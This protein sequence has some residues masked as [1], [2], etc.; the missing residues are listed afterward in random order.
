MSAPRASRWRTPD[1]PPHARDRRAASR[2]LPA[3]LIAAMAEGGTARAQNVIYVDTYFGAP[4]LHSMHP[5]GSGALVDSLPAGTLPEGLAFSRTLG[6]LALGNSAWA[7]GTL[8]TFALSLAPERLVLAGLSCARGVAVDDRTGHIFWTTSK[9]DS[10]AHIERVDPAGTNHVTVLDLGS[11]ANPRGIAI[12]PSGRMFYAD[13]DRGHVYAANLDGSSPLTFPTNLSLAGPWGV[14]L[15]TVQKHVYWCNYT[16]GSIMSANY[17]GSGAITVYAGLQNPTYLALDLSTAT[18]YW[19]EAGG[20]T[21]RVRSGPMAGSVPAAASYPIHGYGGIVF[22]PANGLTS[23]G[24]VP[25]AAIA[26]G[27]AMPNPLVHTGRIDFALP[28]A[29]RIRLTLTDVQG[30]KVTTLAEGE[31]P[32]GRH[33]VP[34]GTDAAPLEPGVYFVRL[35]AASGRWTRRIVA[36]R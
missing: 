20:T 7:G 19:V 26:L 32:A 10:S 25:I 1:A 21:P 9:I 27:E 5:D 23:V 22:V 35:E 15:D 14:A 4:V 30:R 3:L 6:A 31:W 34:L 18:V 33:S 16:A 36:L 29:T 28:V 11:G 8:Q 17:D 2:I 12:D 13:F 24:A